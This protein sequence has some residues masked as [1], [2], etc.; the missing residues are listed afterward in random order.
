[1]GATSPGVS[2]L[3]ARDTTCRCVTA[4]TSPTRPLHARHGVG[5]CARLGDRLV[6]T[7]P[8]EEDGDPPASAVLA[9][10]HREAL[11]RH[12]GDDQPDAGPV[13]EPRE[14][15]LSS[16]A[17]ASTSTAASAARRRQPRAQSEANE[18]GSP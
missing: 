18:G 12:A 2:P 4:S 6:A 11:V 5:S 9:Q 16:D 1:M 8:V 17:S 10:A 7:A 13:V 15:S 14:P 3:F